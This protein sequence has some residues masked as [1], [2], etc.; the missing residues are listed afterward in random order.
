MSSTNNENIQGGLSVSQDITAGGDLSVRG[1]SIF[2]HDVVVKG[3]L[4]AHNLKHVNKGM[5]Q[6]LD[7]LKKS[8]PV[9]KN[10]W[11]AIVGDTLPGPV[12]VGWN[13]KWV[14]TGKEGGNPTIDSENF[15][16]II[17]ISKE[18]IDEITG[19]T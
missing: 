18:E 1:D 14:A 4:D 17:T 12:Y 6:T 16:N 15:E 19:N 10:G 5:F 3:W 7:S 11:W 9:P 13:G 8:Y 2:D